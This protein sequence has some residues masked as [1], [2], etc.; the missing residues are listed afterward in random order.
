MFLAAAVAAGFV[1]LGKYVFA[2]LAVIAGYMLC[3]IGAFR[4]LDGMS[5]DISGY[6]LVFGELCGIAVYALI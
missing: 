6:A 4:S 3:L 2:S 5:G 1:V